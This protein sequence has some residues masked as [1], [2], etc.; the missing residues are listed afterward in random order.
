MGIGIS[1]ALTDKRFDSSLGT[2]PVRILPIINKTQATISSYETQVSTNFE[3]E[4]LR[5]SQQ[6]TMSLEM[7]VLGSNKQKKKLETSE[8]NKMDNFVAE[9]EEESNWETDFLQVIHGTPDSKE[10]KQ[11]QNSTENILIQ[12]NTEIHEFQ[13]PVC[14]D[15]KPEGSLTVAI[16]DTWS[17]QHVSA[18]SSSVELFHDYYAPPSPASYQSVPLHLVEG[19]DDPEDE[20]IC[21][22]SPPPSQQD[23]TSLLVLHPAPPTITPVTSSLSTNQVS[24]L[25]QELIVP[26]PILSITESK[27]QFSV[28]SPVIVTSSDKKAPSSPESSPEKQFFEEHNIMKWVIDDQD[29]SDIPGLGISCPSSITSTAINVS[30]HSSASQVVSSSASTKP[31]QQYVMIKPKTELASFIEKFKVED[32]DLDDKTYVPMKQTTP[33]PSKRK[34]GRPVDTTPREITQKLPRM[35]RKS[36]TTSESEFVYCSDS[37]SGMTDDEVSALKY[38]R[39]RDLN[40]EASKR[41]RENR[42][43][44]LG[45]AEAELRNLY[46]KNLQLKETVAHYESMVARLKSKFLQRVQNPSQEIALARRRQMSQSQLVIIKPEIIGSMMSSNSVEAPDVDTFWST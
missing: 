3:T 39:M 7:P 28:P 18:P 14:E 9:Q 6:N 8:N 40:N 45:N 17:Q 4:C 43:S 37:A 10:A 30:S 35:R 12:E 41:C 26:S 32:E 27:P 31:S 42:K 25:L 21:V 46:E 22:V 29:R 44:K 2:K 16:D 19:K 13:V 20:G 34:R 15:F 1:P 23:E 24:P 11:Q 33:S 36:T 38:R 5:Q